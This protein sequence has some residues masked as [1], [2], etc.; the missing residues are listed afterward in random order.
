VHTLVLL[1]IIESV[2]RRQQQGDC[3]T[4][5]AYSREMLENALAQLADNHERALKDL[6]TALVRLADKQA[7]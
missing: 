5:Q 2:R 6:E 4:E 7:S 1:K 3:P